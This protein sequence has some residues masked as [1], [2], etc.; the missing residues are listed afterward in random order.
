MYLMNKIDFKEGN[1]ELYLRIGFVAAQLMTGLAYFFI[2]TKVK[3]NGVR[4]HFVQ[5]FV[6]SLR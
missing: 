4:I 3:A 1:N 6:Q 2:Y 5:P